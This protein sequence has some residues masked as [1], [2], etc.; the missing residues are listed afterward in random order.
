MAKPRS[1]LIDYSVYLLVRTIVCILQSLPMSTACALAR[2]IAW[3]AYAIDKRHRRVAEQNL[4]AAFGDA[5]TLHQRRRMVLAVYEHFARVIVEIAFIPRKLHVSNWKRHVD[6]K[7]VPGS[8]L[9]GAGRSCD[10][11]RHRSFW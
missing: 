7:V 2:Y 3:F 9:R 8:D 11:H 10:D 1:F 5:L 4:A 6:L